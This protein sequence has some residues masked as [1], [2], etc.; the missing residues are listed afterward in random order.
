MEVRIYR[1][2]RWRKSHKKH[3]KNEEKE[4]GEVKVGWKKQPKRME[5]RE[6]ERQ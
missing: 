5:G 1:E 3:R 4:E 2:K 6:R